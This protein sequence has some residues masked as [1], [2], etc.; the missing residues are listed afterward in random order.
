M[1]SV[2]VRFENSELLR[3]LDDITKKF[4]DLTP[5]LS[6]WGNYLVGS[7]KRRFMDGGPGWPPKNPYMA[8]LQRRSG[9]GGNKPGIFR[10]RL[11]ASLTS[12]IIG[13]KVL[14]VGSPLRYAA[15]YQFGTPPGQPRVFN[16]YIVPDKNPDGTMQ[17]DE[18]GRVLGR[19]ALKQDAGAVKQ[20]LAWNITGRP[21]LVEP[22]QAEEREL[23]DIA[24]D[25]LLGMGGRA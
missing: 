18:K 13:G 21:F 2:A 8:E 6:R 24:D 17:R 1:G 19:I 4:S 7:A 3:F 15:T 23:I 22:T 16:L 9:G 11:L 14:R 12:D 25:A 20:L 10:G 5:L